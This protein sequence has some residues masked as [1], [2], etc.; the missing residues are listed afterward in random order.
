MIS[1]KEY[2][3]SIPRKIRDAVA[4]EWPTTVLPHL[5]VGQVFVGILEEN[6]MPQIQP[7][8]L[9]KFG[10]NGVYLRVGNALLRSDYD[11][12]AREGLIEDKVGTAKV[13]GINVAKGGKN[14]IR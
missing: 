13:V 11:R 3:R 6:G 9:V 14:G 7:Y 4:G 2:F 5:A 10:P 8:E 1:S 12:L